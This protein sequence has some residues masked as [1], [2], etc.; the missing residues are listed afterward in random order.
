MQVD[1]NCDMGESWG[2]YT[3]GNDAAML[4]IVSS[5]NIACGFHA[6]DPMVIH[7][8]L[9]LAQAKRVSPGAHPGFMDLPG[10]GRRPIQGERPADIERQILYQIGAVAAM[11][12]AVG[13]PISH[14]K[15]HGALANMAAVDRR[16]ADAI[17]A[18]VKAFDAALCFVTLP[19]SEMERAALAAGLPV[20]SEIFA[21]R[22]YDDDGLLVSTKA[23]WCCA[24]RPRAGGRTGGADG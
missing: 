19:H 2:A 23:A 22:A 5:A 3:L 8:T 18:A 14:V 7:D 16:L 1:L 11:A 10:F 13:T 9:T 4:D 21:D 6:G 24:A 12:Q 15:A 17:V 20:I